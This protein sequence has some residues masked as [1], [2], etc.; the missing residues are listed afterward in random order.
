MIE[1]G[2]SLSLENGAGVKY[3]NFRFHLHSN[4]KAQEGE[5]ISA[6]KIALI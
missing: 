1:V 2:E 5:K 3:T 4:G 6:D